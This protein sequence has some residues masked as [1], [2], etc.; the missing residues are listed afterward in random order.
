MRL[1]VEGRGALTCNPHLFRH[2]AWPCLAHWLRRCKTT[3]MC[4]AIWR[5]LKQPAGK[6]KH[7]WVPCSLIS[8][9]T[10][11]NQTNSVSGNL[12][13]RP[14]QVYLVG[15]VYSVCFVN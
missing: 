7:N 8:C 9:R 6:C 11:G 5:G 14:C 13:I 15:K 1:L 2:R 4:S 3:L 12:R 10:S